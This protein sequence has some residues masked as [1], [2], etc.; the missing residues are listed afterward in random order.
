MSRAIALLSDFGLQD[1][2]VGIV[3]AVLAGLAPSAPR[4]D[5]THDVPPQGVAAGSFAL[6]ASTRYL[7]EGTVVWAV[8]DPGV[9]TERSVVAV[10]AS[11]SGAMG[12]RRVTFVAPDNGLLTEALAGARIEAVVRVAPAAVALPGAGSTF[13]GRDVFAPAVAWLARGD[14]LERLGEAMPVVALTRIAPP[15]PRQVGTGWRGSVR[16]IDRFGDL[17]TNLPA[18][19]A[20]ERPWRVHIATSAID[21]VSTTFASVAEGDGVAYVGSWGTLEIAVRGGHA[22]RRWGAGIGDIVRLEPG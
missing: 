6:A 13:H 22:A 4:I 3:H 10:R 19:V 11:V 9:G 21:G 16:W 20:R 5:L 8:V 14:P 2:Y 18:D 15:E 17:I 12:A 1:P 7:P